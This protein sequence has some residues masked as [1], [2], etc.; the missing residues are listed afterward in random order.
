MTSTSCAGGSRTPIAEVPL[1]ERGLVGHLR[2][3][4][5]NQCL[6]IPVERPQA[7]QASV[8][9]WT[10]SNPLSGLTSASFANGAG[11]VSMVTTTSS[12][13]QSTVGLYH[14]AWEVATLDE[15]AAMRDRLQQAGALVGQSD[16]HYNKSLY[17]RDPDGLEF[18]VHSVVR[19]RIDQVMIRGLGRMERRVED[20]LA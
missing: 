16:H 12:A 5:P 9:T 7:L 17:C 11:A 10:G 13:G 4:L 14:I 19:Q 15:L 3:E 8:S 1:L 2:L 6:D 18:E 20:G